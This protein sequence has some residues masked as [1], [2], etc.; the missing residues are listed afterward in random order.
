MQLHPDAGPIV[1]IGDP[2]AVF[3]QRPARVWRRDGF[4]VVIATSRIWQGPSLW[5]D[6]TRV[7]CV[8]RQA[9]WRTQREMRVLA[10]ILEA[11][12]CEL[13]ALDDPR[14]AR[15]QE[16]WGHDKALPSVAPVVWDGVS[17]ASAVRELAPQAVFGQEAFAYGLAT[18]LSF[19]APRGLMV[20]GGDVE[21]FAHRSPVARAL[22]RYALRSVDAVF[23]TSTALRERVTMDFG[24][25]EAHCHLMALGVDRELFRPVDAAT[26]AA[27]R[28]ALDL[29]PN[30]PVVA[31]LRRHDPLWGSDVVLDAFAGIAEVRPDAQFLLIG[32]AGN[33]D[34]LGAALARAEAAGF[35]DRL[36][37]IRGQIEQDA[38]ARALQAADVG[39]S[40]SQWNEPLSWSVTQALACGLDVVAADW[41]G[42]QEASAAGASMDLVGATDAPAVVRLVA[43]RLDA[44]AGRHA[45]VQANDRYLT[46][47]QDESAG[48]AQV[49]NAL[50]AAAPEVRAAASAWAAQAG[51]RSA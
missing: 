3:V 44:D 14:R 25:G 5:P 51:R 15:A 43:A 27:R 24:V 7:C 26:R 13:D 41:L 48:F 21:L 49:L 11:L 40:L 12:E 8:E 19:G 42:Y 46:A 18:A 1:L 35:R 2:A 38:Y 20:W 32:G 28:L 50:S 23:T 39:L 34:R 33:D 45:R 22:V 47:H 37:V 4:D 6:G 17:I 30:R 29:D 16:R 10:P 9:D 31:S 36:S